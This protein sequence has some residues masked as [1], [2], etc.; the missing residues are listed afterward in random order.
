M[1]SMFNKFTPAF[2][3]LCQLLFKSSCL[4]CGWLG[5]F[6]HHQLVIHTK[7]A[8]RHTTQETLHD[9]TTRHMGRQ[10]LT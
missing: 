7:L 2:V 10:H 3:P 4:W 1:Y 9:D 6:V 8:L 5:V